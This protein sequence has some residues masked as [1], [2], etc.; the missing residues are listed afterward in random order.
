MIGRSLLNAIIDIA[1]GAA[2][3]AVHMRRDR[4]IMPE[5]RLPDALA[6]PLDG[7]SSSEPVGA[8]QP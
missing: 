4:G 2:V 1:V 3:L 5:D 8:A 7:R 6:E